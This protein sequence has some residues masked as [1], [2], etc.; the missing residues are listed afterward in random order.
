[1]SNN[2][3]QAA[4]TPRRPFSVWLQESG[5]LAARELFEG[6][7]KGTPATESSARTNFAGLH[8]NPFANVTN[9]ANLVLTRRTQLLFNELVQAIQDGA[10]LLLLTGEVGTGK[11]MLV[12]QL[13]AWLSMMSVPTAFL[14]NTLLDSNEFFK[15][16]LAEFG[17][18]LNLGTTQNSITGLHTWLRTGNRSGKTPVL[19]IDEAQSL[20]PSVF[21]ALGLL[22]N[23]E[24]PRERLLQIVLVGQPDL[25]QKLQSPELRKLHQRIAVR[26]TTAPFSEAE[27]RSYVELRLRSADWDGQPV[28]SEEALASILH[29]SQGIPRVVNL[30]C[31]HALVTARGEGIRPVPARIVE[32]VAR[33]FRYD[34]FHTLTPSPPMNPSANDLP[35][36]MPAPNPPISRRDPAEDE[37]DLEGK[38]GLT[39]WISE[40]TNTDSPRLKQDSAHIAHQ[41]REKPAA[42]LRSRIELDPHPFEPVRSTRAAGTET[43]TWKHYPRRGGV[44]KLLAKCRSFR[45]LLLRWLQEPLSARRPSRIPRNRQA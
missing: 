35:G 8:I 28:F 30:L 21:E 9:P 2:G 34:D 37:T 1:M 40:A 6:I 24:T 33:Q 25:N 10:G 38:L 43:R 39:K 3:Q 4:K 11:T 45:D 5:S 27:F 32:E 12:N 23:W 41:Q 26:C 15:L 44:Y 16:A 22:L 13:R 31:E 36:S 20:S 14:F 18:R 42:E 7:A 19:I 17:I 29:Y